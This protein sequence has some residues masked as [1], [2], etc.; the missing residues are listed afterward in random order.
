MPQGTIVRAAAGQAQFSPDRM[1]KVS[2]AAADHLYAGL[3][4][5]LPGQQHQAHTHAGQ[6]KMYVVLDG[7]GEVQ[8]GE[9]LSA[10]TAGDLI[11]AP[12][13]VLHGIRNTGVGPLVVLVVFSPPPVRK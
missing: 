12:A 2:L 5:L 6:D 10:V 4:C 9:E 7:A 13:G 1:G 3:N 11:L 8:L